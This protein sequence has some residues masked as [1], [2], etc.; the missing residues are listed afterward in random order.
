MMLGALA[1][2]WGGVSSALYKLGEIKLKPRMIANYVAGMGGVDL[3][4]HLLSS[5]RNMIKMQRIVVE[6]ICEFNQ[7]CSS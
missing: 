1:K 5:Y 7:H 2:H 6:L 4:D 3:L